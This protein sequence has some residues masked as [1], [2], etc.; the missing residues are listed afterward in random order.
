[1]FEASRKVSDSFLTTVDGELYLQ[2]WP[3]AP[4]FCNIVRGKCP[5]GMS[6]ASSPRLEALKK[7]RDRAVEAAEACHA[8]HI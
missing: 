6:L 2:L 8:W 1:M 5:R 3:T 4:W 7:L